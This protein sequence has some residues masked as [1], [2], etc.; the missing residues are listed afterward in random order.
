LEGLRT[1]GVDPTCERL[2]VADRAPGLSTASR[3]AIGDQANIKLGSGFGGH[4]EP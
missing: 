3:V 2:N 1:P 4:T